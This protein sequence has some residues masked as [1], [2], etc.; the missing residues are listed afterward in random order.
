MQASK[1]INSNNEKISGAVPKA[2][3]QYMKQSTSI[4]VREGM[5]QA[6]RDFVDSGKMTEDLFNL[7]MSRDPSKNKKYIEW[8]CR[9][10]IDEQLGYG[11]LRLLDGLKEFDQMCNRGIIKPPANDIGRYKTVEAMNDVVNQHREVKTQ[12]QVKKDI[13]LE[14]AEIKF[15]ND[16]CTLY[17]I[18]TKE[19][20]C[21]YG[22]GTKWC[23]AASVRS[24]YF[25]TYFYDRESNLLYLI[26]KGPY[27]EKYGKWACCSP[28]KG[29]RQYYDEED[30]SHTGAEFAKICKALDVPFE[31]K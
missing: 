11:D 25:S 16:K 19:A 26:P 18:L 1:D 8:I 7:L 31:N 27:L 30:K 24:N 12:A 5:S 28:A 29:A 13:K 3:I 2:S 22:S 23:T 21:L 6:K 17:K 10:F 20:S 4:Q 9:K 14:G 15:E